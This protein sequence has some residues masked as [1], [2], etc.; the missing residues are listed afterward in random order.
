[1]CGIA[2][3]WSRSSAHDAR[4][5]TTEMTDAIRYRGPDDSGCWVDASAGIA[6]GHRRLSIIDLSPEGHQPMPSASGRWVMAFN[7]EVYNFEEIRRQLPDCRWRGHSDTEVMLEAIDTW[8]LEAAVRRF[9]G[10]FAFALWDRQEQKLHLVR[11]RL[12]IKPL[13]YGWSGNTFLFASELKALRAHPDFCPRINRDALALYVRHN[14]IPAPHSIYEGVYK[15]PPGAILTLPGWDARPSPQPYWS[16]REVAFEGSHHPLSL[17]D[18]EAVDQLEQLLRD[19]VRLRMVADVPLGAFL[20]GGV[21]S[22]VVVALMQSLS[23]RPVKTF[24]IGFYEEEYDEA[25]CAAA[26]ARHL[27]TDHAEL[28]VTPAEAMAVIPRLPEMFDEP[29]ADS[30]QIPTFLVSQ[31]A[32]RE[33]TVSLSGDGG[34][35]LFAGYTR[36][37]WTLKTCQALR[38]IPRPVRAAAARTMSAIPI[39]AGNALFSLLNPVLPRRYRQVRGGDKLHKLAN[40]LGSARPGEVYKRALTHW[41]QPDAV[42]CG[43]SEPRTVV[44]DETRWADVGTFLQQMMFIDQVS[45][46]PDDIL[47]KVD[48]ASMAVSL[49]ARVPLLDHRVVEFAWRVPDNLKL[50][51]GA[52]KWLLRQVLDRYVPRHLIERPKMGFG[53]PIGHWMR[54]PLRDWAED[55]LSEARLNAEGVFATAL[56]RQVWEDHL[57]GSRNWQYPL[58]DI[59]MFQAWSQSASAAPAGAAPA[60]H[61]GQVS[62]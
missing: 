30:S 28:Y 8:G 38:R 47:T 56:V 35:E 42:V 41:S 55:L 50:R 53:V 15:L 19:A 17:P 22:S 20:S 9:L 2:G 21:D 40:I 26:V 48:R 61:A 33:V 10:M 5:V 43:G 57:G 6:L 4:A 1:M 44:T 52:T 58:W 13:Y 46:L 12:G 32:R 51:D 29:F 59:L 31:L 11:D 62:H 45:Y 24:S 14:Y 27:G 18:G 39:S 49:E 37:P 3:F 36:Y 60:G 16:V 54:G 23:S 7:G 25:K 34:D